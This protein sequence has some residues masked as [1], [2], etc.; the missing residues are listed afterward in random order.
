M[1]EAKWL[2]V[3]SFDDIV[4]KAWEEVH[5]YGPGNLAQKLG[6]VHQAFMHGIEGF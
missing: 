3:E 5:V 1:F 4:G 6:A 2:I